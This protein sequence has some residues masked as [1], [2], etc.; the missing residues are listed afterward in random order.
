ML[1]FADI[2]EPVIECPT[3]EAVDVTSGKNGSTINLMVTANDIV[4]GQVSVTCYIIDT[5]GIQTVASGYFV[6]VGDTTVSCIAS[7][8]AGN[9]ASCTFDVT[10]SGKL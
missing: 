9:V 4:D 2:A 7:D 5:F 10:V 6:Q 1:C 3:H 8:E